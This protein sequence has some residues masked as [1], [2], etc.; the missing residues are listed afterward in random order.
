M[1]RFAL[2]LVFVDFSL[3]SVPSCKTPGAPPPTVVERL[4]REVACLKG[5]IPE[6]A[7][8]YLDVVNSCL[9]SGSY[10][11][12]LVSLAT[13]AGRDVIAC[14]VALV[15]GEAGE[16]AAGAGR[17]E[18]PQQEVIAGRARAYLDADGAHAVLR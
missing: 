5:R 17:G 2:I 18:L 15:G 8:A 1:K 3:W 13:K 9:L 14:A 10:M 6:Q 11:G 4:D 12:C 16:M 7:P